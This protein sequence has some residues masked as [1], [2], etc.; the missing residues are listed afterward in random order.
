LAEETAKRQIE[1][2][3][4]Y[5]T[6]FKAHYDQL[7]ATSQAHSQLIDAHVVAGN[8]DILRRNA[9]VYYIG[10]GGGFIAWG[11]VTDANEFYWRDVDVPAMVPVIL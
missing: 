1:M 10:L 11:S 6:R 5:S 4:V 7:P 2:K 3:V 8:F 9:W